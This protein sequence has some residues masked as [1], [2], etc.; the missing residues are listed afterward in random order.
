MSRIINDAGLAIVKQFEGCRL[1]P[2]KCPAGVW[3]VGW[4]HT[5]PNV[6]DWAKAGKS[7]TQHQADE[8]LA[9]DLQRFEEAVELLCPGMNANQFSAC[10]SFSFNVGAEAFKNST[11]RKRIKEGNFLVAANEFNKWTKAAGKVLP[12]LVKRRAAE[13]ALFLTVPS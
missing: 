2:Y 13:R 12:G 7:L 1:K 10:V 5:G 6:E 3:T 4:G 8:I 9:Y 11:L